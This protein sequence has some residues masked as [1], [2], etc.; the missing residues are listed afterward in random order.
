MTNLTTYLKELNP[1]LM[2]PEQQ[3]WFDDLRERAQSGSTT[4]NAMRSSQQTKLRAL[5]DESVRTEELKAWY[6]EPQDGSLFQGTSVSSLTIPC[7]LTDPIHLSSIEQLEDAIADYYIILH[8]AHEESVQSAIMEDTTRWRSEGL[9]Y[10]IV[11]SSKII[12]QAFGL[13]VNDKDVVFPVD[14]TLVDPHEII[15]YSQAIRKKYFEAC[16]GR[17]EC[18]EGLPNLEQVEIE[19]SLVLADISKPKIPEYDQ[20]LILAPIR[21]N[22]ICTLI[23]RH[24]TQ[25]ITEKT[26]GRIS[27]RSLMVTIYDTDTPYT[28][29]QITGYY[30]NATGPVL[31]GLTVMGTSGTIEAFRWLYAYR[32]SLISQKIM[33]SS[34]YSEVERKFYPFV[35]FGVLVERDAEILLDLN[36]LGA[37]RYR[38]NIS[39]EIEFTY[40]VQKFSNQLDATA[41]IDLSKEILNRTV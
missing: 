9:Y 23:S 12:S 25:K 26:N 18:F 15:S 31:P 7:E 35:F 34:L 39:P 17:I 21:C 3:R 5:F 36:K 32:V 40:L 11:L 29:H 38:G 16:K 13:A 10:G 19:S 2:E 24:V 37:L 8:D 27:P 28:Y 4:F 30:G 33:K 6:G 14:G 20:K 22:E 1:I 41:Q